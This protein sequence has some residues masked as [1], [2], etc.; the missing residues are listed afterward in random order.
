V[1]PAQH[2]VDLLEICVAARAIDYG[3]KAG[4]EIQRLTRELELKIRCRRHAAHLN[5]IEHPLELAR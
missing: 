4:V 3:S 5:A 1:R 2:R